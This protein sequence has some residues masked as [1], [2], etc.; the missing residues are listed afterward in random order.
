MRKPLLA[1]SDEPPSE[2]PPLLD[3]SDWPWLAVAL[4][5]AVA[6]RL[7]WVLH[8]NVDPND[9]RLDDS[10]FYH[11]VGH[12]LAG[13][14]GYLNPW[15]EQVTAAWP[16]GYP[17]TLAAVYKLFGWHLGLAKALNIAFGA[18]TVALVYVIGRRAFDQRVA[19]LGSMT[20]AAFPSQIYFSTL[21]MTETFFALIFALTLLLTLLWTVE[22]DGSWWQ[23]LVLGL[24]VGF[25]GLVRGE[26]L[27]LG[28]IVVG[29]WL[30]T[31]RPWR[32]IVPLLAPL[33]VGVVLVLTPW[34]VRNAVQLH[35]FVPLREGGGGALSAGLNPDFSRDYLATLYVFDPPQPPLEE[36]ARHWL[37]HPWELPGFV[38][39]KLQVLYEND[40]E[41]V[42]WTQVKPLYLSD[43]EEGFF[44]NLSNVYFFSVGAMALLGV[45][46][47]LAS[48][49]GSALAIVV[50]GLGWSLAFTLLFP[51]ARYHFPVSSLASI[52]GAAFAVRLWDLAPR[53]RRGERPIAIDSG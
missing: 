15:T 40:D 51:V 6:L 29:L 24:L 34:T 43:A 7:L 20:L 4:S 21:V 45:P 44:K 38:L 36:S 23:A 31:V 18:A 53:L 37:S 1:Q 32:R 42:F 22:R 25:A 52:L 10:V 33:T 48:G 2:R 50:F 49:R 27:L 5:V 47:A 35:E 11:N 9:G 17:A 41:G 13:G 16:P 8:A 19:F 12:L 46:L 3:R 14:R 28:V 26:G 30:L 39:L